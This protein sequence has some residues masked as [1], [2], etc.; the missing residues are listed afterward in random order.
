[1]HLVDECLHVRRE[2]ARQ[3]DA[4]VKC[5]RGG[6]LLVDSSARARSRMP[7]RGGYALVEK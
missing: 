4:D 2:A 3:Q 6:I 7:A 1:L 5:L